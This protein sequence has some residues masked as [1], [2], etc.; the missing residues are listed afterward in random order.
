VQNTVQNNESAKA[1]AGGS[2]RHKQSSPSVS[3]N[4]PG[5]IRSKSSARS[6]V[7][8]SSPEIDIESA[9]ISPVAQQSAGIAT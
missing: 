8:T 1:A 4:G 9:L 6:A 3:T 7:K 5:P 2:T